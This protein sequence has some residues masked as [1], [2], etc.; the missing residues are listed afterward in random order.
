MSAHPHIGFLGGG[1]MAEAI[2]GGLLAEG[3][4]ADHI[5]VGEPRS[6]RASE[7]Q[8]KFAI[9]AGDDNAAVIRASD[10]LILAVKPQVMH[11]VVQPLRAAILEKRP[12]L[13]SIA[14]GIT[15]ENLA[16]WTDPQ[17]NIVRCMPNTPAL[18]GAGV[19]GLCACPGLSDADRDGVTQAMRSVGPV[20]WVANE[21]QLDALMAISGCGPAYFFAFME[22][23]EAAGTALGLAPEMAAALAQQT[24]WGAAKL[25]HDT[26]T[27]PA[28]LRRRVTSPGGT[29]QAALE[30][31]ADSDFAA[32]VQKAT[33]A[34]VDR[35][36]ELAGD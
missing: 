7:L 14:A 12:V 5:H 22:H 4:P 19:S 3:T 35:A 33:Q 16:Q 23:L 25:V 20:H 11:D 32:I 21:Q 8:Q 34:A 30:S 6:E 17:L 31:F 2:I 15:L 29:T 18:V 36:A 10:I 24:A 27:P 26:G 13:V 1:N 28:E 9:D